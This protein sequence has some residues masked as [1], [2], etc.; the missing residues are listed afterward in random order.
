MISPWLLWILIIALVIS[1]GAVIYR[2]LPTEDS[3]K[4]FVLPSG[5]AA[6]GKQAFMD[7]G[8]VS[9]HTVN[10]TTFETAATVER[11]LVVH[12][13]GSLPRVKTYGQLVTSIIHPSE[14][15]RNNM[16]AYTNAEGKSLMPEYKTIMTVEQLTNTV[17]FLLEHY[18]ISVPVYPKGYNVYGPYYMP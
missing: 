15:I 13:G 7:L 9:C 11:D 6:M 4:G 12:L 14:S 5:D 1:L 2:P 10:G 8:C 16:S 17:H 18:D 3:P